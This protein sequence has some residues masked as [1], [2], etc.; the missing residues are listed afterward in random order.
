[1]LDLFTSKAK[2]LADGAEVGLRRFGLFQGRKVRIF[3]K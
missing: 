2:L 3:Y 1:M